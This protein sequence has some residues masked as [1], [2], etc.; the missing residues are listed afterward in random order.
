MIFVIL[1][2]LLLAF[3]AYKTTKNGNKKSNSKFQPPAA[4][5]RKLDPTDAEDVCFA[6]ACL[7]RTLSSSYM[8]VLVLQDKVSIRATLHTG[9]EG[10][11]KTNHLNTIK[12]LNQMFLPEDVAK[13]LIQ[14]PSEGVSLRADGRSTDLHLEFSH[15][16]YVHQLSADI[17]QSLRNGFNSSIFVHSGR[18]ELERSVGQCADIVTFTC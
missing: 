7:M 10:Y 1:F 5:G 11:Y 15:S 16:Y 4:P 2:L 13:L 12:E 6:L 18:I 3:I 9:P 8:T 17:E 14:L